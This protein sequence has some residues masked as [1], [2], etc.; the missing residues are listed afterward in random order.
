MARAR[1]LRQHSGCRT[2]PLARPHKRRDRKGATGGRAA[3][4][5]CQPTALTEATARRP[6]ATPSV[7]HAVSRD[8][9][10]TNFATRGT[11]AI[12]GLQA[13]PAFARPTLMMAC[14]QI[15][16]HA[17]H[18]AGVSCHAFV[19]IAHGRQQEAKIGIDTGLRH[20]LHAG[21]GSVGIETTIQQQRQSVHV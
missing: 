8:H 2:K 7:H 9:D 14:T 18:H 12:T 13:R 11:L 4:S 15:V 3:A 17:S 16:F 1:R 6:P 20:K 21:T 19:E 10:Q 5:N